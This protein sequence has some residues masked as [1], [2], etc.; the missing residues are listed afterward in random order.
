MSTHFAH[1]D[2]FSGEKDT[3][4]EEPGSPAKSAPASPAQSPTKTET[5][6][7]AV[8]PSK[9]TEGEWSCARWAEAEQPQAGRVWR[10]GTY[11]PFYRCYFYSL[12]PPLFHLFLGNLNSFQFVFHSGAMT[13]DLTVYTLLSNK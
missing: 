11:P 6:S 10:V 3:T 2:I 8:S 9:S 7:P 13:V 4:T 1:L 5:K 12:P